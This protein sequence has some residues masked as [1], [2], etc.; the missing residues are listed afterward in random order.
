[1]N[2]THPNLPSVCK[3]AARTDSGEG[4][5]ALH[6]SIKLGESDPERLLMQEYLPPGNRLGTLLL[7]YMLSK[8]LAL[9]GIKVEDQGGFFAVFS[10]ASMLRETEFAGDEVEHGDQMG[11]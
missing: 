1:M 4:L 2:T 8:H 10:G 5:V 3:P 9:A 11:G 6:I 7:V